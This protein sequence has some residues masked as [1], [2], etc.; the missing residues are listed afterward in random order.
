MFFVGMGEPEIFSLSFHTCL[1][2]IMRA[3]QKACQDI[4][5]EES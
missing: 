3:L 1:I 4:E 5:R 2:L